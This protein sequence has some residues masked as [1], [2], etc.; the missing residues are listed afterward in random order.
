MCMYVC[1]YVCVLCTYVSVCIYVYTCPYVC[2]CVHMYVGLY[3]CIYVMYIH[4]Y[5]IICNY[6]CVLC[7]GGHLAGPAVHE[8]GDWYD[9]ESVCE[10]QHISSLLPA[11][12]SGDQSSEST[13]LTTLQSVTPTL[14]LPHLFPHL[15]PPSLPPPPLLLPPSLPS[16]PLGIRGYSLYILCHHYTSKLVTIRFSMTIISGYNVITILLV[17]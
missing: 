17:L 7:R 4:M 10:C 9:G 6:V 13:H 16:T 2:V 15:F 5:N 12:I 14:S 11:A 8:S 1:M 3:V